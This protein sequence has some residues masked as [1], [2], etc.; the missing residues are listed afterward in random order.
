MGNPE[1]E[2]LCTVK[3][4]LVFGVICIVY[5]SILFSLDPEW[6]GWAA[7]L[8]FGGAF[9]AADPP[10]ASAHLGSPSDVFPMAYLCDVLSLFGIVLLT[11]V[12]DR[13]HISWL[14][15]FKAKSESGGIA[16]VR[17]FLRSRFTLSAER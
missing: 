1:R 2:P 9:Y 5:G 13:R 4:L 15:W 10:P 16:K 12:R 3:E 14:W 6:V 17:R 7:P 8:A 11:L